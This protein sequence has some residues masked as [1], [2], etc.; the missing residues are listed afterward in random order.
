MNA[1]VFCEDTLQALGVRYLL[2]KFFDMPVTLVSDA[3]GI[4]SGAVGGDVLLVASPQCV[5]AAM[6]F[7]MP[8]RG[9]TVLLMSGDVACAD[10]ASIDI[11]ADE[12]SMIEAL[13][14]VV[15]RLRTAAVPAS[16]AV[17][18]SQREIDVLRLVALGYINKEIAEELSISINT[19]LSH[20][21]NI[22]A[23]LG[24][25]SAS[26]WSFYAMM[27]GLIDAKQLRR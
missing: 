26:G 6:D 14:C 15:E 20:R 24:I 7:F 27:N 2:D 18:L 17:G 8:R 16:M 5:A 25:R 23:K 22:I 19:V 3:G 21:K 13:R 12:S 4:D 11:H 1:I 10:F 9:Q